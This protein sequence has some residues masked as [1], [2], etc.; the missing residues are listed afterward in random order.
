[1]VA[2]HIFA[3]S[4]LDGMANKRQMATTPTTKA[5][6]GVRQ[7]SQI[8]VSCERRLVPSVL[9]YSSTPREAHLSPNEAAW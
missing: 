6:K 7:L 1:L 9:R 8:W 2:T 5:T 4:G 3:S